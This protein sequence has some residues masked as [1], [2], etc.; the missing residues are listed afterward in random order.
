MRYSSCIQLQIYTAMMEFSISKIN[1]E[2]VQINAFH[3][4]GTNS[5]KMIL[6]ATHNQLRLAAP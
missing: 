5:T 2:K 3:N 6:L 4:L 1:L